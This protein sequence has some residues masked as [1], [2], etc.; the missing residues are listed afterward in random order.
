M[1]LLKQI[2][3]WSLAELER[4]VRADWCVGSLLASGRI[5]RCQM[6]RSVVLRVKMNLRGDVVQLVRT[7]PCHGVFFWCTEAQ[8]K[9]PSNRINRL[10]TV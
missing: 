1:L 2:R 7:L 8:R 3:N 6:T 4:A 10:R 5:T 9:A